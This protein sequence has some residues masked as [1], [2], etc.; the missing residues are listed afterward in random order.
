MRALAS[1]QQAQGHL[2]AVA[3]VVDRESPE[4]PWITAARAEGIPV[5][6]CPIPPRAYHK[7]RAAIARICRTLGPEIVH[8]HGYRPDVLAGSVARRLGHRTVTT[9]HG[10]TGGGMRNR[11]YEWLQLRAFRRFDAVVAV[12]RPLGDRLAAAGVPRERL[13]VIPNAYAAAGPPLGR[14]AARTILGVPPEGYRL[15]WAGRLSREKGADV[16]VEALGLLRDLPIALS[17]LGTGREAAALAGR[18]AALGVS[19]RVHWHGTVPDAARLLPA[20]DCFV[21]SSRTEGTPMV[22][23]EAMAAGVPVVATAVGGVPD[24]VSA[25]EALLIPP[26]SPAALAGAIRAGYADPAVAAAR[27][28]AARRRLDRDYGVAGW[29]ERY[30]ATYAVVIRGSRGERA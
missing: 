18:A 5:Y 2:V 24:I 12:A 30:D 4:H 16:L 27:A 17:V 7:E 25:E 3:A 28:R 23:F 29:V 15:G 6:P 13:H 10:F 1:A 8:T 21:L 11:F 22:L 9:V 26:E 14:D 20:F 19:E